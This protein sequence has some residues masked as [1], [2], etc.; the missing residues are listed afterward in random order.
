MRK[1][2][3]KTTVCTLCTVLALSGG[4]MLAGCSSGQATAETPAA[5]AEPEVSE[6]ER[7]AEEAARKEAA[8]REAAEK[9]IRADIT[10]NLD[11]FKKLDDETIAMLSESIGDVTSLE[12]YGIDSETLIR[13][14]LDGFDYSIESVTV[15]DDEATAKIVLTTKSFNEMELDEDEMTEALMNDPDLATLAADD[16]AL[17]KWAGE[18]VLGVVDDIEP[19]E[20]SITLDYEKSGDEWTPTDESTDALETIFD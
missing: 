19:T 9:Y 4:V 15:E 16:D 12:D 13:A 18:Y 20:K 2:A 7:A 10:D 14:I 8:E 17:L 3:L 1:A 6:E 11:P 5:S